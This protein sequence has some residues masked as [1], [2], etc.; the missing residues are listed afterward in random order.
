MVPDLPDRQGDLG[1]LR[2]AAPD[3]LR[4]VLA[5]PDP[6][7]RGLV[8]TTLEAAGILVVGQAE[9]STETVDAVLRHHPDILVLDVETL[10][11][12]LQ[13]I[14]RVR[15][16][17]SVEVVVLTSRVEEE[18]ALAALRAGAAGYIA[19]DTAL[20]SLPSALRAGARG[21]A[22]LSRALARRV[23]EHL[24]AT[25]GGSVGLRPIRSELTPRQWQ[26]LD[27]LASG[28][29]TDDIADELVVSGDT[30]RSHIKQILR[31]LHARSRSDAVSKARALR[32]PASPAV[33][34]GR[35]DDSVSP[36]RSTPAAA[37]PLP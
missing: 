33:P 37:R 32:A 24:Q 31:R 2:P 36:R 18:L 13:V 16:G 15:Y 12:G 5:D 8:R 23:L 19:K 28:A 3:P 7:A 35:R 29:S 14:R 20:E 21:E 30:V 25:P 27:L 17:G 11:D 1:V 9:R 22:V 34:R 6:L 10:D 4:V 26:V